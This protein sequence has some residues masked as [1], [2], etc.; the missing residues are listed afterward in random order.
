MNKFELESRL[1]EENLLKVYDR[2]GILK[3]YV[4]ESKIVF[5]GK[6]GNMINVFGFFKGK[7]NYV[8]FITDN[9]RG[10]PYYTSRF[11]C[12]EEACDALY[13]KIARLKR[14]HDKGL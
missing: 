11:S 9:E 3:Q 1:A 6:W 7:E 13:E 5:D 10:I 2:D 14:I 4:D 8:V 12:E